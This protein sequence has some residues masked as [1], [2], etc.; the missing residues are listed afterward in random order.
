MKRTVHSY[1][2]VACLLSALL[3]VPQQGQTQI[4]VMQHS[5]EVQHVGED[6]I[7]L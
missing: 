2:H 5:G 6:S 4:L 7:A 3:L 1:L